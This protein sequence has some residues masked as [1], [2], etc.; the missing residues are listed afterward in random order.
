MR[1]NSDLETP[2]SSSKSTMPPSYKDASHRT[3]SPS[4]S[5][6]LRPPQKP[7]RK[8]SRSNDENDGDFNSLNASQI[9]RDHPSK[10]KR[11]SEIYQ[12]AEEDI[13]DIV[14][15]SMRS[16]DISEEVERRLKLKEER[17]KMKVDQQQRRKRLR[18]D[19]EYTPPSEGDFQAAKRVKHPTSEKEYG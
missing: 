5:A 13:A 17:R 10:R 9:S 1:T 6:S 14:P 11:T 7:T 16:D 19:Q 12:S 2:T 18:V 8:R 3:D 15:V 4:G